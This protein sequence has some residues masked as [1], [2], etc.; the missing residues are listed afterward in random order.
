MVRNKQSDQK[1]GTWPTYFGGDNDVFEADITAL[2]NSISIKDIV[3]AIHIHGHCIPYRAGGTLRIFDEHERISVHT[4]SVDE[5]IETLMRIK[6]QDYF[7]DGSLLVWY[8]IPVIEV[9]DKKKKVNGLTR[10]FTK[11]NHSH[12]I[13][14]ER[15][16]YA[17]DCYNG[18]RKGPNK[19][20]DKLVL[21]Y[22][23]R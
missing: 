16:F 20:C 4:Q 22:Y 1:T 21:K 6:P 15:F 14:M 18:K 17:A 2:A 5:V 7:F 10:M 13:R 3:G 23:T 8:Y 9:I 11:A 12:T 19:F